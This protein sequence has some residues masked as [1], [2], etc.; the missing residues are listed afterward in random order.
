[1]KISNKRVPRNLFKLSPLT[2]AVVAAIYP[3]AGQAADEP[4]VLEEVIVTA[5][6]RA[7]DLQD[8]GQSITAFSTFDIE[9]MGIKSMKDY[10]AALPSV[11]LKSERPGR[12]D[13]V[14]R[15]VSEDANTWYVDSQVSLYLDETPMTTSSQQVSVRAIDLQRIEALPGPQGTL[16]GASSQTGTLRMITNKP[17]H[18]GFSG[19]IDASYGAI[20]GGDVSHDISGHLNIPLIENVLSMRIVGYTSHDGGYV[21]NV[22]GES[23]SG[24]INNSDIV[25]KDQTE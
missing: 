13:L 7:T 18:D 9:R 22:Y 16:F 25:A 20:K 5:T 23:W 1:M 21:D 14:M 19:A 2:A 3:A 8:V 15:G 4:K 6:K 12:N 17:D 11:V 10:I 24:S